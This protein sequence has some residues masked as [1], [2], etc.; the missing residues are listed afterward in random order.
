[1]AKSCGT[2]Y[3][4]GEASTDGGGHRD[5]SSARI[6]SIQNNNP[7]EKR[8]ENVVGK[9]FVFFLCPPIYFVI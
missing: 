9:L 1:M 6:L 5:G 7:F 8:D 2:D 3:S 4:I